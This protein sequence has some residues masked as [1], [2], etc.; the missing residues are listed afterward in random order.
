MLRGADICLV[1]RVDERRE[2]IV[3]NRRVGH[4]RAV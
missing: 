4:G 3:G 2:R 1:E